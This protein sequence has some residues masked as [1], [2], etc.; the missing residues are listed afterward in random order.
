MENTLSCCFICLC[1]KQQTHYDAV[2]AKRKAFSVIY[3]LSASLEEGQINLHVKFRNGCA[4]C[5][6]LE[7]AARYCKW[8]KQ[9]HHTLH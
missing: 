1:C 5:I 7:P 6:R 8:G 9:F 3:L 2:A 4:N